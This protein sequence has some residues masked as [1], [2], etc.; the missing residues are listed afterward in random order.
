MSPETRALLEAV[1]EAVEIPYP[2]TVGDG[3]VYARL[4]EDRVVDLVVFL[5]G[6]LDDSFAGSLGN[7][8]YI[9]YLREQLAKKPPTTYAHYQ[10]LGGGERR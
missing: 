7:D 4:L 2:A 3:E 8:W 10:A 6:V 9:A 5:R 1:R